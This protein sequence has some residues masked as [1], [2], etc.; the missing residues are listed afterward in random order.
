M[1]EDIDTKDKKLDN[2]GI[3]GIPSSTNEHALSSCKTPK[4]IKEALQLRDHESMEEKMKFL[5]DMLQK[6]RGECGGGGNPNMEDQLSIA[7]SEMEIMA[8]MAIES[9]DDTTEY[10][11]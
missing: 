11:L 2:A 4:D 5:V 6:L 8:N 3:V 10:H 7:S 1:Q 9:M